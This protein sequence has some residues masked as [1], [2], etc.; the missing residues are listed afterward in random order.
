[1]DLVALSLQPYIIY[2]L[3]AVDNIFALS[4]DTCH[5]LRDRGTLTGQ[6]AVVLILTWVSYKYLI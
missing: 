4:F 1:M 6:V 3:Y 2:F 5:I